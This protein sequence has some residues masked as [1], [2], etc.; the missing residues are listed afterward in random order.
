MKK[1]WN[2]AKRLLEKDFSKNKDFVKVFAPLSGGAKTGEKVETRGGK[3]KEH[4]LL[5]VETFKKLFTYGSMAKATK[6]EKFSDTTLRKAIREK[7]LY[8]NF[9]WSFSESC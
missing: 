2:H 5:N 6:E 3:N 1:E 4:L 8:N 7:T 9:Y